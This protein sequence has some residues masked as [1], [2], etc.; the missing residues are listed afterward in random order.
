MIKLISIAT[1]WLIFFQSVNI[2]IVDV[3]DFDELIEHAKF[4]NEQYGDNFIVFLS[5]HYGE[6]K[7]E[8]NKQHQEE[9]EQHEQLP[10]QNQGNSVSLYAFILNPQPEPFVVLEVGIYGSAN[11][12]YRAIYHSL[13]PEGPFQPPRQA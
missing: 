9:K 13:D 5:K 11:Y 6:L 10:F 4:H 12:F 1:S 8:H 2:P 3:V 7:S